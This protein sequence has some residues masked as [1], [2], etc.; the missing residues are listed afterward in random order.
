MPF[1]DKQSEQQY[2]RE[3][4]KSKDNLQIRI[5]T[6]EKYTE[7]KVDFQAWIL[8]QVDWDGNETVLD[9]GCGTGGYAEPC[10]LRCQRY[11]A[12][13]L[14]MGMLESLSATVWQ[15]V[16]LNAETIPFD[17]ETIDVVL[18]NHMLYHV[19]ELPQAI[20]EI[21]RVLKPGGA[22]IAATNSANYMPELYDLQVRLAQRFDIDS[23]VLQ[24]GSNKVLRR[25]TLENG[26][27]DLRRVFS[28]V[29]RYDLNGAL[30]FKE[31][32]PLIDYLSTMQKRY[33]AVQPA[34]ITWENMAE[35]LRDEL[36]QQINEG[37]DYRVSKLAGV[38]VC[39]KQL[40][41]EE[42]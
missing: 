40:R 13:D 20:D 14:S 6:H 42:P 3:Q 27:Q 19:Q 22:L 29:E 41:G 39:R 12:G 5:E 35:L 8:D 34:G 7:P 36:S 2:I 17:D 1:L 11:I 25:F 37:G 33:A 21:Y 18:A 10:T 30:V 23:S 28:S 4:Y 38:F 9:V 31:P 15:K 16:N 24:D 32:E 26:G